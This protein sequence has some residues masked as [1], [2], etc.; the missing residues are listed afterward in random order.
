MFTMICACAVVIFPSRFYYDVL[1]LPVLTQTD[2]YDTYSSQS[3]RVQLENIK[4]C[5]FFVNFAIPGTS[6]AGMREREAFRFNE[7]FEFKS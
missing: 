1:Y 6:I 5:I 2:N 7:A 3:Q 4:V